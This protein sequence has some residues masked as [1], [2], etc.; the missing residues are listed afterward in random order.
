[1]AVADTDQ[2]LELQRQC[3]KTYVEPALIQYAVR[4]AAATRQPDK[5][6]TYGA[7]PRASIHMIECAPALAFLRRRDYAPP[8]D[9][10]D[11]GPAA[12]PHPLSLS[13]NALAEARPPDDL[14]TRLR[15]KRR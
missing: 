14:I 10:L 3:R 12:L 5:Y 1:M 4:L 15:R 6:L 9:V 8:Q 13:Y 11:M 2:L 7:S